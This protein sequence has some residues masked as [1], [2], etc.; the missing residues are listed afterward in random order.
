MLQR[1]SSTVEDLLSVDQAGFRHG[2]TTCDQYTALAT[3]IEKGFEKTLKTGAVFLD[4]TAAYD[5]IWHTGLLY[6]LS[7]Y[8]PFWCTQTVEL[9]LRNRRF[10]VHMGDDVSSW[11]SQVNGLLQGSVLALSLIHI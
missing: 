6:K 7:K 4:L 5:T 8:L 11:R 2:R 3:F 1:I 10:R 9:L